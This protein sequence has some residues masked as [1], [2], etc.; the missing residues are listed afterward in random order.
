[1]AAKRHGATPEEWQHFSFMLGLTRDLLPVVSD[2]AA[3]ISPNSK[4]QKVGKTPS[5]YNRDKQVV[6]IPDWT[7]WVASEEDV[8]RWERSRDYG[9]CIQTRDVRAIDI[10]MEDPDLAGAVDRAVEHALGFGLPTRI[11]P[12]SAKRLLA[13]RLA[14]EHPKEVIR[15]DDGVGLVS[16]IVELL[17]NG[18]QFIAAGTHPSGVKYEWSGGLPYAIPELTLDQLSAIKAAIAGLLGTE[19]NAGRVTASRGG[20]VKTGRVDDAVSDYL[21]DSEWFRGDDSDGRVYIHCPWQSGHSGDSG[22]TETTYFPAGSN[23]LLTGGWK[24][25][26]ASCAHRTGW[27]FEVATGVALEGLEP[28]IGGLPV[29]EPMRPVVT[30]YNAP[31]TKFTQLIPFTEKRAD[32]DLDRPVGSQKETDRPVDGPR[33]SDELLDM[34][35]GEQ[36]SAAARYVP[37][38]EVDSYPLGVP[39]DRARPVGDMPAGL[40]R[41]RTGEIKAII[42]NVLKVL[43][44]EDLLG[45]RIMRD[46]FKEEIVIGN[47]EYGWEP[48]VDAHYGKIRLTLEGRGFEPVSKDL[49]RDTA[50]VLVHENSFDSAQ[51]WL[52]NRVWDGKSRVETFMIDYLGAEDTEYARSMGEYIWTGLPGRV[53]EPGCQ[54]DMVP[55]WV[56]AQG[57]HKSSI[58]ANMAPSRDLFVELDLQTRET[59]LARV[60]RGTVIG[61]L[62]ELKGLHSKEMESVKAWVTR[63]WE[64]LI[65][66]YEE[67]ATIFPRRLLIVGTTNQEQMLADS[68]GNRRWGPIRVGQGDAVAVA[69][70]MEQLWA[71]GLQMWANG[72]IRWER[73]ERLAKLEHSKY[74]IPDSWEENILDWLKTPDPMSGVR[75]EARDWVTV[76]E[77][78]SEALHIPVGLLKKADGHRIAAAMRAI[79]Y[80]YV[81]R[82][83]KNRNTR[84]WAPAATYVPDATHENDDK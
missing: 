56:S 11:R 57:T 26:H 30:S 27:D 66:K 13:F 59:D 12:N 63:R 62:A 43:S 68:T 15:Y 7:D 76:Q 64:K 31:A 55:I 79:N 1:M 14:G 65:Q 72:G 53:M 82:R 36:A 40:Q 78:A 5:I 20:L 18:Q 38:P 34:V 22:E 44:C 37:E 3:V 9:I 32:P 42:G 52:V 39:F 75:P 28:I 69:R 8:A 77:I 33:D 10:D 47:H 61:E 6:G 58:L 71:E 49:L 84:V 46:R 24:C 67:F 48:V 41:K 16:G 17:M 2:P 70:D 73:F 25:L 35:L 29:A 60:L 4:I 21:R 50:K 23:G 51:R 45:F 80:K 81:T 54:L 74:M 83:V 19:W